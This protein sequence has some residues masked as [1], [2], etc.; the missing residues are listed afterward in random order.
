[1]KDKF[2]S[3][4]HWI[5]AT[6]PMGAINKLARQFNDVISLSLGDPD[7]TTHEL[8]ANKAHADTLNGHT[9][10]T[11]F[12]GDPELRAEISKYYKE[13][14]NMVVDD[15]EI[16]V[17]AGACVAMHLV[18]EAILDD[19]D[20]V[21]M[22]SP[23]FT[24]Y[25]N[26]IKLSRGIP[27]ELPTYEEEDFQV[28]LERF[29]SMI[30]ERTRAFILNT[31]SNPTGTCQTIE[32]LK[33]IAEIAIK[34]DLIVIA[35]DIYTSYSYAEPFVPISS[36]E[37][38]YERTITINTSSKNFTMT[39]WRVGNI[40]A[41]KHIIKTIT[42][43]NEGIVFTSPAPSQRA[44]IHALRNRKEIQPAMIAEYKRRVEYAAERIAKIPNI[45]CLPPRG[46]FYVF[47]NIK[48]TGLTSAQVCEKILNEAHIVVL[49]GTAFGK[50]GEGYIRMA[51]TV[52]L[53]KMKE[54]FDRLEKVSVFQTQNYFTQFI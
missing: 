19:G 17:S 48:S 30:T 23:Y 25:P 1:M 6:T 42:N 12:R 5:D 20:E 38:M 49:P 10:Y 28:N 34:H 45:S 39:G 18:L 27:V 50:C 14:Y 2:L 36:I 4:R 11:E 7:I 46:T 13:E 41:P 31:P 43:V 33:K 24:P 37:G 3:K 26:Q 29:E 44:Y 32:S 47:A 22:Q 53:D 54:A 21:I 8:I 9:K 35:D 51:C 15:E 16:F 40:I 52:N